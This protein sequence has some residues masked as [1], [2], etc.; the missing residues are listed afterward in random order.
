MELW[1]GGKPE[2]K[3]NKFTIAKKKTKS[4]PGKT[5]TGRPE[6]AGETGW[7]A[8]QHTIGDTVEPRMAEKQE[9]DE[10]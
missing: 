4:V 2:V 1:Q 8:S 6:S 5:D 9:E 10:C 3:E 7:S